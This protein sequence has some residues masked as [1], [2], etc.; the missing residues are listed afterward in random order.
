[1]QSYP[2]HKKKIDLTGLESCLHGAV[3]CARQLRQKK[4]ALPKVDAQ[5]HSDCHFA[6]ELY[7]ERDKVQREV[8][9]FL[10]RLQEYLADVEWLIGATWNDLT[11][12]RAG[13]DRLNGDRAREHF[14]A[15]EAKLAAKYKHYLDLRD[16]IERT[17]AFVREILAESSQKQY[18]GGPIPEP[19]V[20]PPNPP[21]IDPSSHRPVGA[22]KELEDL[23][24][25]DRAR[26]LEE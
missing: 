17:I 15:E 19:P 5:G 22:D 13:E 8:L 7:A 24:E 21:E 4:R 23:F 18:P 1:M 2:G 16:R 9:G 11:V 14:S 20:A 3:S 6:A 10:K 12:V 26:L 25:L